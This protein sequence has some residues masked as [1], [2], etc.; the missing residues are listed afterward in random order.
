MPSIKCAQFLSTLAWAST[1]HKVHRLSLEQGVIDFDLRNQQLIGPGK[2][3]TVFSRVKSY[4]NLY[5]IGKFRKAAIKVTKDALLKYERLKQ[6]DLFS[7][8][9]R[10]ALSGNTITVLLIT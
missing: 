2:M 1:I 6:N 5:F 3:H 8:T 4:D 7:T 9:K 10:N